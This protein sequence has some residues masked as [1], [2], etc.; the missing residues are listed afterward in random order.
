MLELTVEYMLHPIIWI[1]V[2]YNEIRTGAPVLVDHNY[3]A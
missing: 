1:Y 2:S 3:D